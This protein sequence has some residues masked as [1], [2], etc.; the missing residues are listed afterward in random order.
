VINLTHHIVRGFRLVPDGLVQD[1]EG[2]GRAAGA[3]Q[4]RS[5]SGNESG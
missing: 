5:G 2:F 1:R 4:Q 3:L